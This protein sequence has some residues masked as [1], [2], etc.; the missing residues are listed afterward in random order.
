MN[1]MVIGIRLWIP[2]GGRKSVTAEKA[3]G[4]VKAVVPLLRKIL[5]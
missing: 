4:R 2:L 1:Q 3:A 5:T